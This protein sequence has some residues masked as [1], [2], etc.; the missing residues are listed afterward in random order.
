MGREEG[1]VGRE[2]GGEAGREREQGRSKEKH[3]KSLCTGQSQ[4]H[5]ISGGGAGTFAL[6]AFLSYPVPVVQECT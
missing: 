1:R 3:Q 5:N 4:F 6:T 2:G